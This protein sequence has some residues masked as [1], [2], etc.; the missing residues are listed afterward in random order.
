MEMPKG[1]KTMG[2]IEE[3]V[4]A[5][6]K[7]YRRYAEG[8]ELLSMGLHSFQ[9]WA[10]DEGAIRKVKGCVLVKLEKVQEFIESFDEEDY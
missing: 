8:E 9:N 6:K 7:I 2:N 3:G 4:K 5:K 1:R 10:K